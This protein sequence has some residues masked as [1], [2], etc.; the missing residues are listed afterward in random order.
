MSA[1]SF[2][3]TGPA[4]GNWSAASGAFTFTPNDVYTGAITPVMAGLD[5]I[6]TPSVLTWSGVSTPQTATFA[7]ST[8]GLGQANGM[9]SPGLAGPANVAYL[10]YRQFAPI[11]QINGSPAYRGFAN[12]AASG[13]TTILANP[14]PRHSIAVIEYRVDTDVA[15]V[16]TFKDSIV[17]AISSSKPL[18]VGGSGRP[19]NDLGYFATATGADLIAHF[20]AAPAANLGI[21]FTYILIS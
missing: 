2:T 15:T 11:G 16:L 19:K 10:A 5:G 8:H 13:D 9:P 20:S 17:G 6:W 12:I 3:V 1:T 14:G 21:D 18:Q 7:P 4:N